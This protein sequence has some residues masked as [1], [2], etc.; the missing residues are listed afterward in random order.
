[1][2]AWTN[3]QPL[4]PPREEL[5]RAFA[6]PFGKVQTATF[7]YWMNG[8]ISCDGIRRDLEAM[9]RAGIDRAYISDIG[10][11]MPSLSNKPGPVKTF[12]PEWYKAVATAF[13]TASRLGIELGMF[14]SPG[15]SQSGGPWVKPEQ[16]MRRVV[17]SC[18]TVEGPRDG[19]SLPA[20]KFESAPAEH[21]RD[22]VAVAYPAP[23]GFA[24]RIAARV[25]GEPL[26]SRA[27][28]VVELESP[29][30]FTAQAA[31][32]AFTGGTFAGKVAVEAELDGSWKKLCET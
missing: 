9:K 20:P 2:P 3:E 19:V 27:A 14:N 15:W 25:S 7:W 5:A 21:A 10:S 24:D 6:D 29:S 13:E 8:N 11:D 1:M 32:L 17:A 4:N 18:V 12:S 28:L 16:A 22:V 26:R 31:E 30:P 23:K